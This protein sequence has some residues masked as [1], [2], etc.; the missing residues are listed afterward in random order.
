MTTEAF[1]KGLE[2]AQNGEYRALPTELG[3]KLLSPEFKAWYEG[4]DSC[5]FVPGLAERVASDRAAAS[6]NNAQG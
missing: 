5:D 1:N 6:M 3:Y 4:Y 2:A